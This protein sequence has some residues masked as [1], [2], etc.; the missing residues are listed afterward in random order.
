M[1]EVMDKFMDGDKVW[2]K[3][4]PTTTIKELQKMVSEYPVDKQ[5]I[6]QTQLE[7]Y[8]RILK[9]VY[10]KESVSTSLD[11]SQVKQ[12]LNELIVK[13][14]KGRFSR[15]D[16]LVEFIRAFM[17]AVPTKTAIIKMINSVNF[18]ADTRADTIV[19]KLLMESSEPLLY[20][21]QVKRYREH[22]ENKD[23]KTPI[24]KDFVAQTMTE[25]ILPEPTQ[26]VYSAVLHTAIANSLIADDMT[27]HAQY[28]DVTNYA[29]TGGVGCNRYIAAVIDGALKKVGITFQT[30]EPS[31]CSDNAAMIA[32]LAH[33]VLTEAMTAFPNTDELVDELFKR[34]MGMIAEEPTLKTVAHTATTRWSG[35]T[36][37][38]QG[39]V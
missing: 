34:G 27:A 39:E 9:A 2:S 32:E 20:Q 22:L 30:V 23:N 26:S 16:L 7:E 35:P 3:V 17:P 14:K 8:H 1:E 11:P 12:V 10:G 19:S 36:V 31:N 21:H 6:V 37:I 28:P 29:L 33:R 5:S 24:F 25:T 4:L 13:D 15:E 38:V 18:A